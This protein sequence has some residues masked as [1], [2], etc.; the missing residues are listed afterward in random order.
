MFG[1]SLQE[2]PE[3]H[4]TLKPFAVTRTW[5]AV[6]S[7]VPNLSI[8]EVGSADSRYDPASTLHFPL[9][10][11][12]V[13]ISTGSA[14]P[15]WVENASA[16]EIAKVCTLFYA[17]FASCS[18]KFDEVVHPVCTGNSVHQGGSVILMLLAT[19]EKRLGQHHA[20][21]SMTQDQ[22]LCFPV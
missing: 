18:V 1:W 14:H 17:D 13:S 6:L 11:V 22:V 20:S 3:P 21:C 19:E 16:S 12:F 15:Y 8:R 10:L 5:F 2:E 9:G 4:P 7:N